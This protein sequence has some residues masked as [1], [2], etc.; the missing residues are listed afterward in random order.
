M[1]I[2][3]YQKGDPTKLS[4]NFRAREFDCPGQ[5]CCHKTLV[6]EQLVDYLQKIREHFG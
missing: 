5:G 6:D 1:A 3:T 2:K 4:A